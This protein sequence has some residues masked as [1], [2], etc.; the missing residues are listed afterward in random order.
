MK[1]LCLA[2]GNER[3]WNRLDKA[4]QDELLARDEVLRQRGDIVAAVAAIATTVRA[5]EGTPVTSNET[6]AHTKAPLAGFSI[7]EAPDLEEAVR[8]VADT[9]CARAKGA[10]ELRP[11]DQINDSG[12]VPADLLA[13]RERAAPELKPM[14]G[15]GQRQLDPFVGTWKVT[16]HNRGGAPNEPDTSLT[17]TER[18]EWLPGGFFLQGNWDRQF[19]TGRH[20]GISIIRYDDATGEHSSYNTD[21]LG[22]ART[23]RMTERGGVWSLTGPTERASVRFSGDGDTMTT[24]WEVNKDGQWMP[25]CDLVGKRG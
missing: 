18:Y 5:W 7:I 8:L 21:N 16:G 15:D 9:P 14:V 10:V 24:L 22:F 13:P 19:G 4:E 1:Y 23:Y 3:D 11:I 17:G 25:L 6:F 2:Y 12:T 20:T